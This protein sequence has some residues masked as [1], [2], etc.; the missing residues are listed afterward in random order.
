[1]IQTELDNV[2]LTRE[3]LRDPRNK[4]G[5]QPNSLWIDE[6]DNYIEETHIWIWGIG[7]DGVH[8]NNCDESF[9]IVEE[10][11]GN[12]HLAYY[13]RIAPGDAK[14][15]LKTVGDLQRLMDIFRINRDVIYDKIEVK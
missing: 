11:L 12:G 9:F 3:I 14:V 8:D 15:K 6:D 4:F 13:F 10:K 1:M 5:Y 2:K 7:K